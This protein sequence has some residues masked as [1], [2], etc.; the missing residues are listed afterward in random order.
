MNLRSPEYG[1]TLT[2]DTQV[3]VART[4]DGDLVSIHDPSWPTIESFSVTI[5]ALS[6]S[7][8]WATINFLVE[9]IGNEIQL[10]DH[11]LNTWE[12]IILDRPQVTQT[13]PGCLYEV[14][15]AFEGKRI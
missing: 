9:N 12:G 10:D 5:R 7:E 11:E 2:L 3:I 4:Q 13:G 14:S 8:R 6:E 1:N 15:F